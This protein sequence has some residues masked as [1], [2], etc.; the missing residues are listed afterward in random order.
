MRSHHRARSL[1]ARGLFPICIA[2]V[3]LVYGGAG[4]G[5]E[6][7]PRAYSISPVGMN[8]AVIAFTRSTGDVNFDPSPLN[9]RKNRSLALA[10]GLG[11][12]GVLALGVAAW[13]LLSSN[14]SPRRPLLTF[15]RRGSLVVTF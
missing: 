1:S 5:Q 15:P 8:F 12:A 9:E 13:T 3:L 2:V 11:S 14:N 7:E 4:F 6:L 10:I